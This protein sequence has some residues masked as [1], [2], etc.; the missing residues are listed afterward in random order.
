M[1]SHAGFNDWFS[2]ECDRHFDSREAAE[3][4]DSQQKQQR[5]GSQSAAPLIIGMQPSPSGPINCLDDLPSEMVFQ[6]ASQLR[7]E[8]M[9]VE[10]K[11]QHDENIRRVFERHPDYEDDSAKGGQRNADRIRGYLLAHTEGKVQ[12]PSFQQI[13]DAISNLKQRGEL[14]L[15]EIPEDK[16]D[17]LAEHEEAWDREREARGF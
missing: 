1:I 8:A 5:L 3:F 14:I 7:E 6:L 16:R 11:A 17:T 13:D 9:N 2:S 12:Y 4:Y 15:K 10:G